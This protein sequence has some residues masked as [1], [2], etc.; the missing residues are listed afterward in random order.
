[1]RLSNIA[2]TLGHL[3]ASAAENRQKCYHDV[4]INHLIQAVQGT[5][6]ER[7]FPRADLFMVERFH[8]GNVPRAGVNP[9]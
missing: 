9:A 5:V 3:F 8:I 4:V 6:S 1:M 2:Q 7:V